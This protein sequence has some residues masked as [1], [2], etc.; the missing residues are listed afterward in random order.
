MIEIFE[1]ISQQSDDWYRIRAGLPTASE[2]AKI[3][4]KPGP[5]GG[6]SGKEQVGRKKL[7][8]RLAGEIITGEP[9]EGYSNFAM[10]RGSANEAEARTMY[11]LITGND[12]K[13]IGFIKNGNCGCSPDAL[14]GSDGL[15]ELKDAKPSVQIERL[16]DGHLPSEHRAQVQGQLMVSGRAWVDFMSHAR[17]LPPLGPIR[18]ERDEPY[19]AALRVDVDEFV[20]E[21]NQL[22]DWLRRM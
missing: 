9:E 1:D 19:I 21:L 18:V 3:I 14:V 5:R 4:V 13:Q 12:V 16:L 11:K 8:W 10:A 7:L 22:V 2:F 17:G 20:A 6:T 15:L